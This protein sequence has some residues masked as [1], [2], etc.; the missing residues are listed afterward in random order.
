[1]EKTFRV[2]DVMYIIRGKNYKLAEE[3]NI[4][5]G[6]LRGRLLKGWSL[7]EACQVPKGMDPEELVYI[8]KA[9]EHKEDNTK[10]TESYYD[11]KLK[12]QRPWLFDG[13]KQQHSRGKW[14]QYLMNTSI[15]PKAVH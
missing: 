11:Q 7:E 12:E 10:A 6:L 13:T 2:H 3:L 5:D 4:S 8:K 14:C 1:M 15:F 9:R